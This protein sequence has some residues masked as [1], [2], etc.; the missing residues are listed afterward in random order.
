MLLRRHP[1]VWLR[2]GGGDTQTARYSILAWRPSQTLEIVEGKLELRQGGGVTHRPLEDLPQ[3]FAPLSPVG[4]ALGAAGGPAGPPLPFTGGWIGFFGYEAGRY[5]DRQGC[6]QREVLSC[7]EGFFYFFDHALIL[8]H[9]TQETWLVARPDRKASLEEELSEAARSQVFP[10]RMEGCGAVTCEDDLDSFSRKVLLCKE[11]IRQGEVYQANLSSLFRAEPAPDALL[12]FERLFARN[13]SPFS[14]YLRAPD[15]E[16]VSSSPERLLRVQGDL[17]ETRPIAGT[18][19]RGRDG[20]EDRRMVDGLFGCPKERAEHVMLVDLAR[21]DLGK[22]AETGSV[23]PARLFYPEYYSHV[24]HIV[25]VI[26]GRRRRG[27]SAL[28]ALQALFPAGTITGCPKIRATE[29]IAEL[30]GRKRHFYTGSLGY[31]SLSGEA[32]FNILIR[33]VFFRAGSATFYAGAGIVADSRPDRE[34]REVLQK[35]AAIREALLPA[36]DRASAVQLAR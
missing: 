31:V 28:D 25:S 35:S 36:A 29:L 6:A 14:A 20:A 15:F 32:D 33:S 24:I 8:D 27:V 9:A 10:P 3:I 26:V 17:L 34:Y 30:E 5:F 23:T 7:P 11:A 1:G 18:F 2:S 16:L 22:I 21:N 19:P 13:P 4:A 12:F